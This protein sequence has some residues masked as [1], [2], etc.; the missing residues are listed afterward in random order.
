MSSGT[1][2][3]FQSLMTS[4]GNYFWRPTVLQPVTPLEVPLPEVTVTQPPTQ[5]TNMR[6]AVLAGSNFV[7]T[8]SELR[9]C[10]NDLNNVRKMIE[11]TGVVIL[12]DLRDRNMTTANWKAAL[13]LAV[14]KAVAGDVIFHMHSHHGCQ[15]KTTDAS[16]ADGLSEVWAP[17]DFDWS[18]EHMITDKWMASLISNL[19]PGVKWIDWADC[20]H[21]A[22]GLRS[23]WC[24]GEKPRFIRNPQVDDSECKA[25]SLAPM[26]IEGA[27]RKGLL[28]AACR[29]SQTSADAYIRGEH[30]GAFSHFKLQAIS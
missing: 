10:I 24:Q 13:Q 4:I 20:C 7:G 18:P 12:A 28:M 26:V 25:F 17:D 16:E 8:P 5:G 23:L 2:N 6:Y 22:D 21:A 1:K 29:S 15:V 30:C 19:K 11:P 9:G 14:E 27:D 3:W